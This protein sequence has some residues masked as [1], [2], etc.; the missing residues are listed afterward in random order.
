M[1][2]GGVDRFSRRDCH[3]VQHPHHTFS[4]LR[5]EQPGAGLNKGPADNTPDPTEKPPGDEV[6]WKCSGHRPDPHVPAAAQQPQQQE[7]SDSTG[8]PNDH[9]GMAEQGH[10]GL[11]DMV[12]GLALRQGGFTGAQLVKT[13]IKRSSGP[14][15]G[16]VV[17]H[18][19]VEI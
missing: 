2:D 6:P 16:G 1:T 8:Q 9:L 5:A 15:G 14:G 7:H 3:L 10:L 19:D 17:S 13:L 18:H 12:G 11:Q 4:Q